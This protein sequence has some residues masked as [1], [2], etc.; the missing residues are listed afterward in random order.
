MNDLA[1]NLR[2]VRRGKTLMM[3][4]TPSIFGRIALI[5]GGLAGLAGWAYFM[6]E[7]FVR[8]SQ[9]IPIAALI[10]PLVISLIAFGALV[11]LLRER[12]VVVFDPMANL[13]TIRYYNWKKVTGE[14]IRK[15]SDVQRIESICRT[16]RDSFDE[17]KNK[18]YRFYI[19]HLTNGEMLYS[20]E[21]QYEND[22]NRSGKKVAAFLGLPYIPID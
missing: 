4:S 6:N 20:F 1:Y 13:I 14:I 5:I 11:F 7:Y 18:Y 10:I 15:M 19:I 22:I 3:S 8:E 16:E 21:S 9:V 2:I 17:T 12:T